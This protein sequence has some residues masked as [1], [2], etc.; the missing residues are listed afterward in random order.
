MNMA[1]PLSLVE[2]LSAPD[3]INQANT[4]LYASTARPRQELQCKKPMSTYWLQLT[5]DL[6]GCPFVLEMAVLLARSEE[7]NNQAAGMRGQKPIIQLT[8]ALCVVRPISVQYTDETI[9]TINAR[10]LAAFPPLGCRDL[11]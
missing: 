2:G 1:T 6:M 9:K 3:C 8:R 5:F 4:E 10:V 7:Q 11:D